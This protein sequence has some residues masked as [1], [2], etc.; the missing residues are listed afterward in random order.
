MGGHSLSRGFGKMRPLPWI[1]LLIGI[2]LVQGERSSLDEKEKVSKLPE[3]ESGKAEEIE[4]ISEKNQ[5]PLKPQ[6]PKP[7]RPSVINDNDQLKGSNSEIDKIKGKKQR[8]LEPKR[9]KPNSPSVINDNDQM[10]GRNSEIDK[11]K[12]KKQKPLKPQRSKPKRPSAINGKN[13][14]K[15]SDSKID[16]IK[17]KKQKPSK[18]RRSKPN[19]SS[20][21]NK[22]APR[23]PPSTGDPRKRELQNRSKQ[24]RNLLLKCNENS[25]STDCQ[26]TILKRYDTNRN[27]KIEREE[28]N[29]GS[30]QIATE[31][32]K[33][34]NNLRRQNPKRQKLQESAKKDRTAL[35]KC[36]KDSSDCAKK[37]LEKYDTNR[38]GRI[39]GY[40][41][42]KASMQI[43]TEYKR[44]FKAL[45]PTPK[46][47][48]RRG[49]NTRR[50]DIMKRMDTL[51]K[52]KKS[53]T[54]CSKN[55]RK[56]GC[57][58]T[59]SQADRNRDGTLSSE[60]KK[61]AER[62]IDTA[63]GRLKKAR[64]VSSRN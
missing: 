12:E 61:K 49:A 37:T 31:Y 33:N 62:M 16:R 7:N 30:R 59:L 27:G 23:K 63:Y 60:E 3:Q 52:F 26:K 45:R 44:R 8:P 20:S 64:N 22:N 48:L 55:P 35:V 56:K 29:V 11:I 1:I 39:D 9:S 21:R 14:R 24:E 25:K 57:A 18:P 50:R 17:G 32:Q 28:L 47:N 4:K 40:E 13:Q 10:N 34:V 41:K 51:K 19:I 58:R 36:L 2:T 38:D 43:V 5:K 6:R 46:E 15:G 42:S 53:L 54:D